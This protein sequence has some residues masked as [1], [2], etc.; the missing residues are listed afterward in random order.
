LGV[1]RKKLGKLLKLELWL[2]NSHKMQKQLLRILGLVLR[3]DVLGGLQENY[4][5]LG[6]LRKC[7]E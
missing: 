1:K 5:R 3:A 2:L 4:L 6:R 7:L